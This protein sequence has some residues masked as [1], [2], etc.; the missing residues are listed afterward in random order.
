MSYDYW[1]EW[2]GSCIRSIRVVR[3]QVGLRRKWKERRCRWKI[4]RIAKNCYRVLLTSVQHPEERLLN[5]P[6][7]SVTSKRQIKGAFTSPTASFFTG[8][9]CACC[10]SL[11]PS[12]IPLHGILRLK[13]LL[14]D[15]YYWHNIILTPEYCPH[16]SSWLSIIAHYVKWPISWRHR[17]TLT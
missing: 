16:P 5:T 15:Q 3:Q 9:F 6:L 7:V 17:L 4:E 1:R 13:P 10:N 8:Y 11:S 14:H 2:K 12:P